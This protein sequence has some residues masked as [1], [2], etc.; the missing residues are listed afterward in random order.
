MKDEDKI[1]L[2]SDEECILLDNAKLLL[3]YSYGDQQIPSYWF[4]LHHSYR[5][6]NE[7]KTIKKKRIEIIDME[8]DNEIERLILKLKTKI[9]NLLYLKNYSDNEP[10]R[11]NRLISD[12][13]DFNSIID[14]YQ[15]MKKFQQNLEDT[16]IISTDIELTE[17]NKEINLIDIVEKKVINKQNETKIILLDQQYQLI[18][19]RNNEF[20]LGNLNNFQIKDKFDIIIMDPP[21]PNS[22]VDR[23]FK[24][25]TMDI[26][27]L[28]KFK[29]NQLLNQNGIFCIWIT[30]QKKIQ[31]F[32][33]EK[34]LRDNQLYLHSKVY[35]VKIT[36][37]LEPVF[38]LFNNHRKCYE[39]LLIASKQPTNQINIKYLFA[40][41]CK[42]HSKKPI[43]QGILKDLIDIEIGSKY[44]ELFAR[45][46][47]NNT[48]SW[49]NEVIKYNILEENNNK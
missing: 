13:I 6:V 27:E 22:S 25:N 49:G 32:I 44:L 10:S 43:I 36:T 46:L 3:K 2:Y 42:I 39:I 30:N 37:N 9:Q 16:E 34:Y 48:T 1:I 7:Q 33:L 41:P 8:I 38:P 14:L 23:N 17:E 11:N 47:V 26:Y 12:K 29:I 5:K 4:N 15:T 31:K 28:Y 45:N 24:Y 40:V 19:P 18:I 21:W 35:W 20:L